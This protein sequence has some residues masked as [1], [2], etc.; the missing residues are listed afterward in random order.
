MGD[1]D[2]FLESQERG[3]STFRW[4][5]AQ[6]ENLQSPIIQLFMGTRSSPTVIVTDFCEAEDISM[7][8]C[9]EFDRTD[10][11]RVVAKPIYYSVQQAVEL[12]GNKARLADGHPFEAF[13][14]IYFGAFDAVLA[15]SYSSNFQHMTLPGRLQPIS[16]LERVELPVKAGSPVVFPESEQSKVTRAMLQLDETVEETRKAVFPWLRCW[17]LTDNPD[18]QARLR[19]ALR[20][21]LLDAVKEKRNPMHEEIIK[22]TV[23]YLDA[24]IEEILRF[25][26][27]TPVTDR[28]A[29]QDTT[30]LGHQIP[31]GT[32]VMMVTIGESILR[33]AFDIPDALRSKTALD[34]SSR[35]RSWETSPFPVEDFKLERWL[36]K[37]DKDP[38][39]MVY[40]ATAGPQMAFGLGPRACFGRR[41]AY[42]ELRMFTAMLIW[43]FDFLRCPPE[44]SGYRGYDGL[45]VKPRRCYVKV[46]KI[47]L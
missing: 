16:A 46:S 8:R 39:Q 19:E 47:T 26:G 1:I 41:L 40:D 20:Q 33:P 25:A 17:Y 15:F 45:T 29:M 28:E 35:V 13:N 24:T 22:A 36:I 37:L 6:T 3:I 42:L 10:F 44:L 18:A 43:N 31:K 21:H 7:R 38:D 23:P 27:T 32:N 14:D 2:S 9:R 4:V 12:W 5:A 30:I 34:A 11:L